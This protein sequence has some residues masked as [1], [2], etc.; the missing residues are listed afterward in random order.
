MPAMS[1]FCIA[2]ICVIG[3][4]FTMMVVPDA[5]QTAPAPVIRKK[6]TN[7]VGMKFV[8]IPSGK[9]TMGSPADEPGRTVE[10]VQHEVEFTKPIFMGVYPVTQAQYKKVMEANPSYF[11]ATGGGRALVAGIKTDDFPVEM[12]SWNSA[13]DF[14]KKL[15]ALAGEKGARRVYRLPTEAEW[16]YACRAGVKKPTAFHCGK[17][18]NT[19]DANFTGSALNRSTKVG[20]YKPNAWGLYDFH[21]NVWH[22]C[23]DYHHR[24]YYSKSPKKDPRGPATGFYRIIRGGSFGNSA[25][26]CRSAYRNHYGPTNT[27]QYVGFRVVCNIGG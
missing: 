8:R 12:V 11:S 14:C 9:F 20:S 18:L 2:G 26:N 1:R 24:D 7:S 5:A 3:L 23:A 10:E 27:S 25:D 4:G 6:F 19:T 17:V 21:G 13:A 22:W 16:E 15:S